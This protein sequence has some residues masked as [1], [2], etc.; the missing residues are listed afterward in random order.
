MNIV[1]GTLSPCILVKGRILLFRENRTWGFVPELKS[2][3]FEEKDGYYER[4]CDPSEIEAAYKLEDTYTSYKGF[5]FGIIKSFEPDEY[6]KEQN[7]EPNKFTPIVN[8]F[9]EQANQTVFRMQFVYDSF[10]Q[11]DTHSK[12]SYDEQRKKRISIYE[13]NMRRILRLEFGQNYNERIEL[14][15]ANDDPRY[16]WKRDYLDVLD[17]DIPDVWQIR[18]PVEGFPMLGEEKVYI[19]KDGVWLPRKEYGSRIDE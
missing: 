17:D 2:I 1:E 7:E 15:L 3:G 14:E 16:G 10:T 11:T 6:V 13:Y 12:Y 8:K 19:K 5:E 9:F 4:P 18:K